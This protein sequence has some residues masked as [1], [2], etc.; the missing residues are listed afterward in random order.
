MCRS[1]ILRQKVIIIII[2]KLFVWI[3]R[4]LTKKINNITAQ[5]IGNLSRTKF[6][7]VFWNMCLTLSSNSGFTEQR[8]RTKSLTVRR[9]VSTSLPFKSNKHDNNNDNDNE[10]NENPQ[11]IYAFYLYQNNLFTSI[12]RCT[13][14][15]PSVSKRSSSDSTWRIQ[16][17][18]DD[19]L[20]F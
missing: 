15:A 6:G 10:K 18:N 11:R 20:Q 9:R 3:G 12:S 14:S 7:L 5:N 16:K 8:P 4:I 19:K 13:Y 1:W 2:C 17:V